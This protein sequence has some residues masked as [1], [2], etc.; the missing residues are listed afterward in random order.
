KPQV[1]ILPDGSMLLDAKLH[2]DDASELLGINLESEEFD[3]LG[4][5]VF[6]QLG[7][8]PT[9]GETVR[10]DGWELR[11]YAIEGHRIR[12]VHAVRIEEET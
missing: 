5:Y 8:Q 7:H 9:E 4:G 3:T 1:E 2:L 11:V 10:V 6:G 12:T